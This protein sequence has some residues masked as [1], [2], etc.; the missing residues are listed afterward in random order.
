MYFTCAL[1]ARHCA[2]SALRDCQ[3][4]V[5]A[6]ILFDWENKWSLEGADVVPARGG[7][8]CESVCK[9]HHQPFLGEA[10]SMLP[11]AGNGLGLSGTCLIRSFCELVH[12]EAVRVLATCGGDFYRGLPAL[13]VNGF[14]ADAAG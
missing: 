5:R 2:R 1:A 4:F 14:G 6:A 12:T 3:A 11:A 8:S 9:R 13:T 7:S 10:N